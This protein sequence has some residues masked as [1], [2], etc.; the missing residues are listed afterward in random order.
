LA[1]DH[2]S[3]V[4]MWDHKFPCDGFDLYLRV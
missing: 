3:S 2:G 1:S 4:V